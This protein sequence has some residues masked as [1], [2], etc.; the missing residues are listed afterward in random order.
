MWSRVCLLAAMSAC[1]SPKPPA[2]APCPDGNCPAGQRC[3]ADVC[4]IGEG[5]DGPA[6]DGPGDVFVDRDAVVD[7]APGVWS[8]IATDET[9]SLAG[10]QS[11]VL[12]IPASGSG[13]LIVVG[14]ETDLTPVT[15]VADNAGN[16]YVAIPNSRATNAIEEFGIELWFA[17][18]TNAGA[19]SITAT[20]GN[21]GE[22]YAVVMWEVAGLAKTNAVDAVAAV[23][24]QATSL[25]PSGAP[26]TTTAAGD[27]VISIIIVANV[28]DGLV[29]NSP[30]TRDESTLGNGWAHLTSAGAQ[31]GVYQT[32]WN[33]NGSGVSC[34]SSVAF[35]VE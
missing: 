24:D 4:V 34:A 2:G 19:T 22:L 30:F 25:T 5:S 3:V 31:P 11:R 10:G 35:R 7:G 27:F 8:L 20:T 29:N 28:L 16:T 17:N 6:S 13:H 18:D 14:I 21:S 15:S 23:S 26:I 32:Q 33:Q 9:G 12:G 1:F